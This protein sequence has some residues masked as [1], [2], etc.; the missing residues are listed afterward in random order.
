MCAGL[1]LTLVE[2]VLLVEVEMG[3]DVRGAGGGVA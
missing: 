2:G 3:V 1:S